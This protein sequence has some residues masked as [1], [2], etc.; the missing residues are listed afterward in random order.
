MTHRHG[1]SAPFFLNGIPKKYPTWDGSGAHFSREIGSTE[2][3]AGLMCAMHAA[4]MA[5]LEREAHAQKR[6]TSSRPLNFTVEESMAI[7]DEPETWSE[8]AQGSADWVREMARQRV[9][10]RYGGDGR[11][12]M[13]TLARTSTWAIVMACQPHL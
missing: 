9:R 7:F 11:W 2:C 5:A 6:G 13:T 8:R 3:Y 1:R 12:V 10:V 4:A